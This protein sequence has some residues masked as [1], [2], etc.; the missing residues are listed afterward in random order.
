MINAAQANSSY[1]IKNCTTHTFGNAANDI[2]ASDI[3]PIVIVSSDDLLHGWTKATNSTYNFLHELLQAPGHRNRQN[4][5]I[6]SFMELPS[7]DFLIGWLKFRL[8]TSKHIIWCST[9]PNFSE[10][11]QFTNFSFQ[12]YFFRTKTTN[13]QQSLFIFLQDHFKI[14]I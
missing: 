10:M 6:L 2:E 11:S 14:E 12:P 7:Q 9:K 13:L 1:E 8:Y 3:L 4:I 5:G